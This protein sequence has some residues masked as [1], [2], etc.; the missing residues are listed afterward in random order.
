MN[1]M[2]AVVSAGVMR[3]QGT[4]LWGKEI[5]PTLYPDCF[6]NSDECHFSGEVIKRHGWV[7]QNHKLTSSDFQSETSMSIYVS[8][9]V[10]K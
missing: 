8:I 3:S 2:G 4:G 5:L 7:G 1:H 6:G 9:Y 10:H